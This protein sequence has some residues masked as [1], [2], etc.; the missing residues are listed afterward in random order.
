MFS[1]SLDFIEQMH[2]PRGHVRLPPQIMRL[3]A[4]RFNPLRLCASER[5][6]A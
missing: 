3:L 5:V 4:A 2:L 1:S 6:N